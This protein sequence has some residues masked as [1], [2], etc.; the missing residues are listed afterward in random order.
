M[1]EAKF[2]QIHYLTPYHASLLNRDDVGL[3][4]RIPFGGSSRI[5]ISSQCLKRHWRMYEGEYSLKNITED[6]DNLDMSVRSRKIF[7]NEIA[8]PLAEEEF[9]KDYINVALEKIIDKVLGVNV[10]RKK[11]AE[12]DEEIVIETSQ[13][14]VLGKPEINYLK[15]LT[16]EIISDASS[17]DEIKERCKKRLKDKDLKQNL[18]ALERA[19]GLDAALFGRMVTADILARGDASVHV[20]HAFSV[21]EEETE[22][23]YFTAVD[24]LL[25]AEGELGSG[26]INETEL[27]SNIYYGYV[28]VDLSQLVSN[29]EGVDRKDWT[30]ADRTLASRIVHN[31]I[32][33][34]A[35]VSPGAKLGSTA[36]YSR[37]NT[38]LVESGNAQPRTLANAYLKPVNLEKNTDPLQVSVD[39]MGDHLKKLDLVY[40]K[41]EDR[42]VVSL[43]E[44]EDDFP[45]EKTDSLNNLAGWTSELVKGA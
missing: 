19:S 29:L 6:M 44:I 35:T 28:V 17:A 16:R 27:T 37:A 1:N 26:H 3:A 12:K 5:R 2:V 20:A 7:E 10:E 9:N 30:G 25:Q 42:K 43:Q 39:A 8:S 33:I 4:K 40:G 24:D 36:P 31:L 13:L 14:I 15:N 32:H 23:D 18:Q 41:N 45:A 21:H 38:L 11:E 22:T 34:I